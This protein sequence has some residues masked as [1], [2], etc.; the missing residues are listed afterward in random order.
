[1]NAEAQILSQGYGIRICILI[2]SPVIYIY[3]N[4]WEALALKY[5]AKTEVENLY[6][7]VQVQLQFCLSRNVV[8]RKLER[9]YI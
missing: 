4:F 3:N 8:G 5:S 7:N 9:A 1:M 6:F 2:W